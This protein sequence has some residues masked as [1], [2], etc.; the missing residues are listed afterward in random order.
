MAIGNLIPSVC[1]PTFIHISIV[2][3]VGNFLF[4]LGIS[5]CENVRRFFEKEILC[6]VGR[7]SFP[8]I[9]IH[10]PIMM[11]FSAWLFVELREANLSFIASLIISWS[12]SLPIL[13]V[14]VYLFYKFVEVPSEKLANWV[15]NHSLKLFGLDQ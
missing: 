14:G 4:L 7:Y 12:C 15:Y 11:S 6:K 1:M 8:L 5:Y 3:A 10:F 13:F 9:L 2:Y